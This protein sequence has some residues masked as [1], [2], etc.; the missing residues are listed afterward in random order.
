MA[1]RLILGKHHMRGT[2]TFL[3]ILFRH[4]W[5]WILISAGLLVLSWQTAF[6]G[7]QPILSNFL[8]T[9]PTWYITSSMISFWIFLVVLGSVLIM[10]LLTYVHYHEYRFKLDRHAVHLHRGI[11]FIQE[12]TIPYQQIS[13]VHITRP[14]HF[15]LFGLARIDIITAADRNQEDTDGERRKFHV[16]I[17]DASIAPPRF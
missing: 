6:G 9:H 8:S 5:L 15:Q 13:N 10:L 16:P 4:H 17:I 14:Y 3:Y 12:T 2:R 1:S 7:L 11:L